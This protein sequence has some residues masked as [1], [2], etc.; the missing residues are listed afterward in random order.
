VLPKQV[1]QGWTTKT[2]QSNREVVSTQEGSQNCSQGLREVLSVSRKMKLTVGANLFA[3][4]RIQEREDLKPL[5][6]VSSSTVDQQY[7]D[8]LIAI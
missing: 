8:D 4:P 5:S 7:S 1:R 6:S 2:P 3:P